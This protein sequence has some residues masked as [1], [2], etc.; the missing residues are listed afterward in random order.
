MSGVYEEEGVLN[1][2]L[3]FH[4]GSEAEILDIGVKWPEGMRDG[5]GFAV[6]TTKHFSDVRVGRGLDL[7]CAV[8]RS[9]FEMSRVCDEVLGI[10]YSG[11]FVE[12]ANELQKTGSLG[13]SRKD[14][15]ALK[16][17][18][19]AELP[20]GIEAARVKFLQGD[21]MRLPEDLGVFDRVH[22]ANLLCRLSE[23]R[24]LLSRFR[25]LVRSGGELVL[26][27]PCTWLEQFTPRENWP[28]GRTLEWLKENL[29]EDFE[30][31]KE[32]EEPFLIRETAR[33]F[34]WTR[35]MVTVWE[36]K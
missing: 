16:T 14:E 25:E 22:A 7:G 12:A 15:G 30:L 18:L 35:S 32:T 1:E 34:Q 13:Y 28:P 26:A 9:S 8:G 11:S 29:S 2:Y 20:E 27:T 21:A 17:T 4:Y 24:L 23:P 5:L 33:K 31:V 10:D 36:R 3:L 19:K 6:R